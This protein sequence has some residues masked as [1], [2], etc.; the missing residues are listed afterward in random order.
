MRLRFAIVLP[1]CGCLTE[2]PHARLS[3]E[4]A[5]ALFADV[6]AQNYRA[7]ERPPRGDDEPARKKAAGPHGAFVEVFLDPILA[8]AQRA[9]TTLLEWPVG[10]TAVADGYADEV[11]TE[12]DLV[13]I[14]RKTETGWEWAQLR[15]DGEGIAYGRLE[16]C[17]ACHGNGMDRIFSIELPEVE[18]EEE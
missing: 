15:G 8:E 18:E 3:D 2:Q 10:S 11:T 9:E 12:V 17:L 6:E 13:N 16:D 4:R 5:E 14:A 1:L 7:W